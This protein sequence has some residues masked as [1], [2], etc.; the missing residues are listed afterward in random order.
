MDKEIRIEHFELHPHP[1]IQKIGLRLL[2]EQRER[3]ITISITPQ[4]A[5]V[6][7]LETPGLEISD[8]CLYDVLCGVVEALNGKLVRIMIHD[9][10]EAKLQCHLYIESP[11]DHYI[12]ID[13][14]PTDA[15]AIAYRAEIPVYVMESVFEKVNAQRDKALNLYDCD[16]DY[17]LELLNRATPE[18]LQRLPSEELNTLLEKAIEVEDYELA[19][20]LRSAMKREESCSQPQ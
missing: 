6:F 3:E 15:L 14:N 8:I 17:T 9:V 13:T 10:V 5:L 20:R 1:K 7:G 16:R 2:D 18:E 4:K 19:C 11:K 12:V